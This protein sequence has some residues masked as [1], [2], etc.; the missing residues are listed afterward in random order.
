MRSEAVLLVA[1]L[2]LEK[3]AADRALGRFC[4]QPPQVA[5]GQRP[6]MSD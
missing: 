2:R 4:F 6:V 3:P 1:G 5:P